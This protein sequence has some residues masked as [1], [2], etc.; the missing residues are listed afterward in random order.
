VAQDTTI[1]FANA[2]SYEVVLDEPELYEVIDA[3][4]QSL[5]DLGTAE[6]PEAA[7]SVPAAPISQPTAQPQGLPPALANSGLTLQP[8]TS[9]PAAV[10][11]PTYTP[12]TQTAPT[13]NV[14]DIPIT[15]LPSIAN[16]VGH[17]RRDEY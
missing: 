7:P 6:Q 4:F 9:L 2:D 12:Q 15:S 10:E 3:N 17:R 5:R 11:N 8:Q 1:V 13:G 14:L 16:L